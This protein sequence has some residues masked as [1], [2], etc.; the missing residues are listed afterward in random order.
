MFSFVFHWLYRRTIRKRMDEAYAALSRGITHANWYSVAGNEQAAQEMR[1]QA[2]TEFGRVRDSLREV[3]PYQYDYAQYGRK[4]AREHNP[5]RYKGRH[6]I[7][8]K[9]LLL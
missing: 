6:R 4:I 5:K 8:E 7:V 9:A 3:D 2:K 1:Q